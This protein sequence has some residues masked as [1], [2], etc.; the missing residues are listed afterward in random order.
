MVLV[1]LSYSITSWVYG[2]SDISCIRS[3]DF[4]TGLIFSSLSQQ[5]AHCGQ[6]TLS[7]ITLKTAIGSEST[8]G[9]V[10]ASLA[11]AAPELLLFFGAGM[12][13]LL[14]R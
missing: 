9:V 8:V 11:G 3:T 1:G 4:E 12:A 14:D 7:G 13:Q 10:C 5:S 6:L 2:S